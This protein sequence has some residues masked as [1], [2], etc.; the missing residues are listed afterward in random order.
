ME[1][2]KKITAAVLAFV[3]A[4]QFCGAAVVMPDDVG[5]IEALIDAHKSMKKAEDLAI[6]D[7][8]AIS[9][10]HKETKDFAKKYN[11]ARSKL[12]QRLADVNSTI[13]LVSSVFS[14]TLQLKNLIE[15]YKD[16]TVTTYNNAKRQPFLL[17]TY[18]NANKQIAAE[19]KS[20]SAKCMEYSLFQTNV[21]KATMEEK[22]QILGYISMNIASVQRIINRASL[23]CRSML[24]T[25]IQ[26]YHVYD[27]VNSNQDLMNKIISVWKQKS[28]EN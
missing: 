16:F 1:Q 12:N 22:R 24:A 6:L 5:T 18:A 14:V 28:Q 13:T 27:L 25:G 21:L 20:I 9:G 15:D 2:Y 4:F 8:T 11:E 17:L 7:L 23:L 10:T 3:L 19:I 26:E